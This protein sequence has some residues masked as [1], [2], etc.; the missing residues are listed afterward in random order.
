MNA[1]F[2]PSTYTIEDDFIHLPDPEFFNLENDYWDE[3][4]DEEEFEEEYED[5]E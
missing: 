4:E 1:N 5:E 3:E 2:T